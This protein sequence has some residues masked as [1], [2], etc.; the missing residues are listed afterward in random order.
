[1]ATLRAAADGRALKSCRWSAVPLVFL[2]GGVSGRLGVAARL[3]LASESLS[4]DTALQ[5]ASR[6]DDQRSA[7]GRALARGVRKGRS[8]RIRV[9]GS[10]LAH[11]LLGSSHQ[12]LVA[13]GEDP[14]V[15]VDVG[16]GEGVGAFGRHERQGQNVVICESLCSQQA[17]ERMSSPA[18]RRGDARMPE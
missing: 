2:K 1:M 18:S 7:A 3:L 15:K 4:T 16:R 6:K 9:L 10:E 13:L 12:V 11:K 8:V 17:V 14:R 5:P